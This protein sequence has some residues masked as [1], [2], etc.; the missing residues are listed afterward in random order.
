M[1]AITHSASMLNAIKSHHLSIDEIHVTHRSI[2]RISC[3]HSQIALCQERQAAAL[4]TSVCDDDLGF[5]S[6]PSSLLV[7][8]ELLRKPVADR[9]RPFNTLQSIGDVLEQSS[10]IVR[11]E[12]LVEVPAV[13]L[14]WSFLDEM[15]VDCVLDQHN[16][17]MSNEHL[18]DEAWV[19]AREK[20]YEAL[21]RR[22]LEK[23]M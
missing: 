7:K 19:K 21:E 11:L 23:R 17:E 8:T 20:V 6:L 2:N 18:P 5:I 22:S 3:N 1:S 4:V 10:V 12:D 16:E 13:V 14:A 9:L 15:T